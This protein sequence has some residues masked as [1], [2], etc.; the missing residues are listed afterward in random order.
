MGVK[1]HLTPVSAHK[2]PRCAH[3][4]R[5]RRPGRGRAPMSAR[6]AR[7]RRPG[8]PERLKSTWARS[9]APERPRCARVA[10]QRRP[11][12]PERLKSTWARSSAPERPRCARAARQRR[13][14]RP[15]R[16]KSTWARSSALEAPGKRLKSAPEHLMYPQNA[17]DRLRK[18]QNRPRWLTLLRIGSRSD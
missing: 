1:K 4:A 5:E 18:V 17:S 2:R 10:R 14:G 3:G 11:G 9:S 15:E 6:A 8:R 13:P 16:P 12:R 7:Q